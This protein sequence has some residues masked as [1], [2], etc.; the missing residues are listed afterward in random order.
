[1]DPD[2]IA[3]EPEPD[4]SAFDGWAAAEAYDRYMGR[5][6]R[7]V[8]RGFLSWL[9]APD[10]AAW[11]DLG[12][13][14]G[15]LT[16]AILG[17][18]NP[19]TILAVDPSTSFVAFAGSRNARA[20]VDVQLGNARQIP[21]ADGTVDVAAAGLVVNFVPEPAQALREMQRVLRPSGIL[22]F[23]VWDYPS[24]GLGFIDAFWKAA[25]SIDSSAVELDES[26]RFP[27]CTGKGLTA[28]CA[29][30]GLSTPEVTLL[31]TTTVFQNFED[32]WIPFTLGAGPAPGYYRSL[33]A[34]KQAVLEDTLRAQVGTAA[35]PISYPANAWA[36][37]CLARAQVP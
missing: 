35:G 37:R 21:A 10:G 19:K 11:L 30:A 14:T 22:G 7:R 6:S 5:W 23:Y 17:D 18:C 29:E 34:E 16:E 31:K 27:F 33:P 24:G 2:M 13:G 9:G 20:R 3:R 32:F 8:A 15:A 4:R 1:M 26:R 12:C 28:L 36:I 25:A